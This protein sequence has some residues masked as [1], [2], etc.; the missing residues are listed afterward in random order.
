MPKKSKTGGNA[1][2]KKK[3]GKFKIRKEDYTWQDIL[4]NN[5]GIAKVIGHPGAGRFK[6]QPIPCG[7]E[8]VSL[9]TNIRIN[10]RKEGDLFVIF[11][12]PENKMR[13][14]KLLEKKDYR[15]YP[16]LKDFLSTKKDK[17]DDSNIKFCD[18]SDEESDEESDDGIDV[19]DI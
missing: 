18:S 12:K 15:Q 14:V 9:N 6:L 7:E 11:I 13:I 17:A 10:I 16:V 8:S 19:E 5:G 2:K 1:H 4:D 3:Q